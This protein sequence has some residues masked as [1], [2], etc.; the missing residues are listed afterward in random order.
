MRRNFLADDLRTSWPRVTCPSPAMTTLLSRRTQSTV[1]ER[2]RCFIETTSLSQV[3]VSDQR[4]AIGVQLFGNGKPGAGQRVRDNLHWIRGFVLS[5]ICLES[6]QQLADLARAGACGAA[7][8]AIRIGRRGLRVMMM[9]MAPS[10][11]LRQILN[12]GELAAL[13]G[14]G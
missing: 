7:G 9:A 4:S 1:V 8:I 11:R 3:E 2:M 13:R 5:A 6:R 10:D 12:V 14:A